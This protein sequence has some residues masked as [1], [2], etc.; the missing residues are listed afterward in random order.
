[1]TKLIQDMT[2]PELI[3]L[4]D[5]MIDE[6][7]LWPDNLPETKRMLMRELPQLKRIRQILIDVHPTAPGLH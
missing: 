7:E 6:A 4:L 1:M 3:A 2:K 5:Q